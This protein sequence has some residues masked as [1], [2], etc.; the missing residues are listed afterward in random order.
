MTAPQPC[1]SQDGRRPR[2]ARDGRWPE[3]GPPA[4]EP[5]PNCRPRRAGRDAGVTAH[6]NSNQNFTGVDQ[7]SER[8]D[9]RFA[10]NREIET[11]SLRRVWPEQAQGR[12]PGVRGEG[13]SSRAR[14][15]P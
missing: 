4:A 6:F 9:P 1:V 11:W 15:D 7:S 2:R 5:A 12:E 3:P 10:K 8:K 14:C 13:G